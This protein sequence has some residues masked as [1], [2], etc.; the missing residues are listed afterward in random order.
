M[1]LLHRYIL[2]AFLATFLMVL[3]VL[4][5][6]LSIGILF[7]TTELIA[8]GASFSTLFTFLMSGFPG[9]LTLSI[10]IASLVSVILVFG[11]LSSDSEISAMRACGIRL[12]DIMAMPLL[13]GVI[14][15]ALCLYIN[16]VLLPDSKYNRNIL[17][18]QV[19]SE[20][21]LAAIHPGKFITDFPGIRLYV[22]KRN[23]DHLTDIRILETMKN[24]KL[25]EIKAR[26]AVLS[27]QD[28]IFTIT[29]SDVT[30]NPI[31]EDRPGIGQA[32][33]VSRVISEAK[34]VQQRDRRLRERWSSTLI[35]DFRQLMATT[36][37]RDSKAY[38]DGYVDITNELSQ[39][40]V[41]ALGCLCFIAIGI[42]LAIKS[43]RKETGIG[44]AICLAITASFY[45]F[46]ITAEQIS[47]AGWMHGFTIAWLPVLLCLALS[48]YLVSRNP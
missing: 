7:K 30:I 42:P 23:G 31:L 34:T 25:R 45:F 20:D 41:L 18:N 39:R 47:N 19:C 46:I 26:T 48:V 10:P 14:F 35:D 8:A 1:S 28:G 9:T 17:V 43:H 44:V 6:V 38:L 22:G 37:M 11:R 5:F 27:S 3:L 33:R 4:S 12:I 29:M 32:E 2:S 21:V 15:T 16:S 13:C 36:R 24:G 40:A